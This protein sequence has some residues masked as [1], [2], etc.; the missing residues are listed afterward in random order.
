MHTNRPGYGQAVV[1]MNSDQ[2][3]PGGRGGV[4]PGGGGGGGGGTSPSKMFDAT[5]PVLNP[6]QGLNPP[7]GLKGDGS[8]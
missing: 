6:S 4:N 1:G 5:L 3:H 8:V 2:H 7:P